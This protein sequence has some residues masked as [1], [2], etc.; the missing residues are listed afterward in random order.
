MR[1]LAALRQALEKGYAD[2]DAMEK[3]QEFD[4]L[5]QMPGYRDLVQQLKKK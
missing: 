1:P 4:G 5:R 3:N 2:L